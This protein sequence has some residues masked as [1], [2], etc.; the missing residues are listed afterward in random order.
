MA[1]NTA[2][3]LSK[4]T[5]PREKWIKSEARF[6]KVNVDG[7]FHSDYHAG[8]TG[9]IMRDCEGKF[10]AA[11]STFLANI[12]SAVTA[13]AY[14]MREGL[15]LSSEMGCNNI[16]MESDSLETIEACSGENTWWNAPSAIYADCVDY[17][18]NIGNVRYRF[19]HREANEVAHELA[20]ECFCNKVNCNW[21]DEPPSFILA[22]LI[23]DVTV[24]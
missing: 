3:I 1:T 5:P 21:V 16:I 8:S 14:A 20:R 23:N 12:D 22:K 19:C 17:A 7:S 6:L 15:K 11:S 18:T 9:A 4:P 2:K 13:E 24:I 10:V